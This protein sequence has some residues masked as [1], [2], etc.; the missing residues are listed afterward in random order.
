MIPKILDTNTIA[1]ECTLARRRHLRLQIAI[2]REQKKAIPKENPG[3]S[4]FDQVTRISFLSSLNVLIEVF[5]VEL[6]TLMDIS[7]EHNS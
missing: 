4:L 1:G 3:G 7:D 5:S 2:L 6:F